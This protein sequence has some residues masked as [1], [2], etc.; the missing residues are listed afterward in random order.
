MDR[1]KIA[2]DF[3]ESLN[4]PEIKKIILFGSVA[5]GDDTDESDIDIL[6]LTKERSDKFKIMDD[7]YSKVMENVYKHMEYI[8]AKIIPINHYNNY[9]SNYFYKNVDEEGIVIGTGE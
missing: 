2:I 8:S 4:H 1:K 3:A 7:V 9:K 5:R 6:I